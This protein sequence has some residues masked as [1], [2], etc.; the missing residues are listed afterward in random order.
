[1]MPNVAAPREF[2]LA[3]VRESVET[4]KQMAIADLSKIKNATV[5]VHDSGDF[6]SQEYLDAWFDIA[7]MYPKKKFYAYT[8]SLHLDRSRRPENFQ[9]VQSVGGLLDD[10]IDKTQSHSQIF[11]T[12]ALRKAA[13]YVDGN[14][15]DSPAIKGKTKIGLVY[16]GNKH[17]KPGQVRWL[18]AAAT[19]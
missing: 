8:K 10:H 15:D 17:L 4:F 18:E 6:F 2:N 1:M 11:T 5:R 3:I 12:H 13:G 9:I 7:R 19:A 16:H 14:K